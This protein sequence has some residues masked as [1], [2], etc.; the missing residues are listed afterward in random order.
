[1]RCAS[2]ARGAHLQQI[3]LA[4]GELLHDDAGIAVVDVDDDF[5]DR[6]QPLAG[7]G[8][9]LNTTFGRETV[10]SKP[11][12][13]MFSIRIAELKLAAAGDVEGILVLVHR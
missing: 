8:S 9:V 11:S 5:L 7:F 3:A 1:M 13:R 10:S 6:L 12:R 4:L 2:A